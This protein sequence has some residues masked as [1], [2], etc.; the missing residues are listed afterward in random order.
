MIASEAEH[1][2]AQTSSRLPAVAARLAPPIPG[3][4]FWGWAGPLLVTA[5][6]AFLRF[7]RLS[8]PRTVIF[9]ETYYVPDAYGILRHGVEQN[10]VSYRNSL[11]A[12]GHTNIFATG[13]EFVV[14]PPLGKLFIAVG[15]WAFGLNPFGWRF[16]VAL[17]G[18]LAILLV[19]RIARRMTRSTL[20]GCVAGL[21]LALDGLEFVMSRTALL[22]IFLM[23]WVLAAF[24][25]LVVDRDVSRTRLAEW[26]AQHPGGE[27]SPQLGTRWWR[28]GAG[29]CLG[30]AC[31]S[32]WDA[33]WYL[34]AFAGLAIAW[35]IGARRAAGFRSYFRDALL[36]DERWVPVTFGLL[37]AALYLAS[38]TGWF[39]TSDGWDR[40]FA[41]Q[42]GNRTPV[43]SDIMS[44]IQYHKQMLSFHVG[45]HT[46]HPYQSQPWTWL[47]LARPVAFSWICPAGG[48]EG[49][50]SVG[51]CSA[52]NAQEVL[53]IGTP[54]IWWASIAT[55]LV[56]LGWW[57]TRRDWRAGAVLLGV[58]AGWLPWFA[59][60]DRTKFYFYAVAFD[61]F[62]VLSITLCLGLII[63]SVKASPARRTVGAT[64]AGAY[65]LGVLLNFA[66]LYP[67]LAS[68]VIP[69][70]AWLHRM[71]YHG[72]I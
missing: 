30:L 58:A 2:A 46:H 11:I 12:H 49:A 27:R 59:F 31:A 24:G 50:R 25:C 65:V 10:Y 21:L 47:A 8:V 13:G 70:T 14:H 72:W 35:D 45:L 57:L 69:Y 55:L 48:V 1:P 32:K 51:T 54:M 53:A 19:A 5:F 28:I 44:L 71:W 15:E 17:F 67:I 61:P 52:G 4:A 29:A 66:Y 39:A 20:L 23:F 33:I 42:N 37:P 9:D 43:I 7:N 68:K 38:W 22:D 16:S 6:G 63:G 34:F 18:S 41:A 40:N 3:S 62:L 64:V 56:C 26:V 36:G 60:P